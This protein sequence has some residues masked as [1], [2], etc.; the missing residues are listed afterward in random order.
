MP[1]TLEE[2]VAILERKVAEYEGSHE[3]L[4]D[5][6]KGAH[7]R[8]IYFE[9][10]VRQEFVDLNARVDRLEEKVDRLEHKVDVIVPAVA[11]VIR[12]ELAKLKE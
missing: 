8:L 10:A 11:Q 6:I 1:Q 5:Q 12:D 4:S 2:R 9:Q 7:Q 3:F